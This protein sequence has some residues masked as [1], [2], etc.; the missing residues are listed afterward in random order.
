[1]SFVDVAK[2]EFERL[3][4][5]RLILILMI[6]LP[7]LLS[8]MICETFKSGTP[9][10]LP[11]ALLDLDNSELSRQF[12]R[13]IQSTPSCSIDYRVTDILEGQNLIKKGDAY[14]LIVV[15]KNFQRDIYRQ[16]TPKL[17]YYYNNQ[18]ILIGGILT[19]DVS[20]V[21][22]TLM[23]GLDSKMRTKKGMARNVAIEQANLIVVDDHV[24]SNPYLNYQYFL[25]LTSFVHI[26]QI[27]ITFVAIW[28][29]GIEFKEG[30]T[31]KWMETAN[32]SILSATFGKLLPYTMI[33]FLITFVIYFIY[34]VVY[35][36][37]INGNILMLIVATLS[38]ILAYQMVGI[39]FVAI[40]GNLRLS[41]SC[42]A[43]YTAM[44]FAFAGT[45]FP[46]IAMPWFAKFW[47]AILPLSH[48]SKILIDQTMRALPYA[49]DV[50]S[51]VFMLLIA[52]LGILSLPRLKRIANSEEYWYKS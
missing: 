7:L 22:K 31:K 13:M 11:I 10:K 35:S 36:A 33:F 9:T 4:S 12:G 47:S 37:P 21:A 39:L 16:K 27:L 1:M 25:S 6:A 42:G 26:L 20:T 5:N 46:I 24:R 34:F 29:F 51:I 30:T 32:N 8:L 45:T 19:K 50:K 43:F 28:A 17:V 38:F 15:P 40:S 23:V 52:S 3:M 44:G 14:A 18:M 49:Y 48:Y 41:L 2:H